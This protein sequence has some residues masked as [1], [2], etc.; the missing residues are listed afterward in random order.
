MKTLHCEATRARLRTGRSSP[1]FS[2]FILLALRLF[3]FPPEQ[4]LHKLGF[5]DPAARRRHK[6]YDDDVLSWAPKS[7][8]EEDPKGKPEGKRSWEIDKE[9]PGWPHQTYDDDLVKW[10]IEQ[11]FDFKNRRFYVA[12]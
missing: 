3:A 12:V 4:V 1:S 9:A 7:K 11:V 2:V 8:P 10:P 6:G 5:G